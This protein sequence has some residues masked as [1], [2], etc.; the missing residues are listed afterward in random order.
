MCFCE[1]I[2]YNCGHQSPEVLR[3]CP[4]TTEIHTSPVCTNYARR[5]ILAPCMCP[6]CQRILHLRCVLTTEWE[7][8]WMHERGVC[9]C[10]VIF[11]DL[12]QPRIITPFQPNKQPTQPFYQIPTG[13]GG[14]NR[15]NDNENGNGNGNSETQ[16]GGSTRANKTKEIPARIH[17]LYGAE[18]IE[19]HRELHKAGSCKCGGDFSYYKTP[20]KYGF[21]EASW[22]A[23]YDQ[24][25]A[26]RT[27][28]GSQYQASKQVYP[29]WQ[30]GLGNFQQTAPQQIPLNQQVCVPS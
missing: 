19:E 18:W 7:H 26:M 9:G 1:F 12:I 28:L 27:Q 17:S 25:Q 5:P 13:S 16:S 6:G 29:A 14:N 22:Q 20:K 3:A 11:P 4:L 30:P 8:H 15:H 2:G 23:A 21:T 24:E 10:P